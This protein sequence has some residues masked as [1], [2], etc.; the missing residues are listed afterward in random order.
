MAAKMQTA[1]E[2]VADKA[3]V[4]EWVPAPTLDQLEGLDTENWAY[5]WVSK[6]PNRIKKFLAEGWSF[7]NKEE[8]DH[9]LHRRSQTGQLDAGR[10]L[11]TEVDYREVVMMKLPKERAEARQR[12][13]QAK[14]DKAV[15][16]INREVKQEAKNLG[17]DVAPRA[18]VQSGNSVTVIE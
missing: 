4:D 5:R 11:T 1:Q 6:L 3:R 13:Y 15:G 16:Q 18:Q 2:I 17:G 8:G 10:A 7:V 12:Y 9:V 14:T